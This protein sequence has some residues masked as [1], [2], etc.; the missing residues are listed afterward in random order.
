MKR[1]FILTTLIIL[2]FACA[3]AQKPYKVFIELLGSSK[4]LSS[5]VNVTV[6]F[7]QKKS[8]WNNNQVLVDENG[9]KI[10]FNSMVDAM[11]YFGKAGWEF[12][13]AYVVT[14]GQQNVYHWLLSKSVLSD[15]ELTEGFT[16]KGEYKEQN[17]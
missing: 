14:T 11:N 10:E 8:V 2:T 5:K 7:G 1:L 9:K 16:T 13:Q 15:E 17:Q 3:S 4:I 6:D 12:E